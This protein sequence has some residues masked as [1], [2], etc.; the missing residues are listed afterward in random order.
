MPVRIML[1]L[2]MVVTLAGRSDANC[3]P[4]ASEPVTQSEM[5][6]DCADMESG[7]VGSQQPEPLRHSDAAPMGM[8]HLGCPVLLVAAE[9]GHSGTGLLSPS[10]VPAFEPVLAGISDIPQTPPPRFG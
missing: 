2:M 3:V 9:P 8:C 1:L 7:P 6:P 5:M 10:Y 4:M